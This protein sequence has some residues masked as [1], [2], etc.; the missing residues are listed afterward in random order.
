MHSISVFLI[1]AI[2]QIRGCK[3]SALIC[4]NLRVSVANGLLRDL[5]ASVVKSVFSPGS[6]SSSH[7]SRQVLGGAHVFIAD[8][9]LRVVVWLDRLH[10]V[11]VGSCTG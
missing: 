1:R 2:R 6:E 11:S 3:S 7:K 4:V 9:T 5:C 8:A 10:L